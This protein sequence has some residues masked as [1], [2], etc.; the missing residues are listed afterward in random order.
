MPNEVSFVIEFFCWL[1]FRFDCDSS[2][3]H[4]CVCIRLCV[5]VAGGW[6][7]IYDYVSHLVGEPGS[8]SGVQMHIGHFGAHVDKYIRRTSGENVKGFFS[9]RSLRTFIQSGTAMWMMTL[10]T[11]ASQPCCD[12]PVIGCDGTPIGIPGDKAH[13]MEPVWV[14]SERETTF[15]SHLIHLN[16]TLVFSVLL[17]L[18][19]SC[20]F[21]EGFI[22][23][24]V[25]T[26]LCSLSCARVQVKPRRAKCG[27]SDEI[28]Q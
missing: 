5:R 18:P 9:G 2:R 12:V 21:W 25:S 3:R 15:I 7:F 8:H 24:T 28:V 10:S 27:R 14:P 4:V 17:F 19:P 20:S 26:L 13:W 23:L 16:F 22:V 11:E 6:E 1:P